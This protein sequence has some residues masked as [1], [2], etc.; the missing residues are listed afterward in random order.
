MTKSDFL[1]ILESFP[2]KIELRSC[3]EQEL[4]SKFEYLKFDGIVRDFNKFKKLTLP[5]NEEVWFKFVSF[6]V[7]ATEV[8]ATEEFPIPKAD[9][10]QASERI[11]DRIVSKFNEKFHHSL[12]IIQEIGGIELSE[13]IRFSQSGENLI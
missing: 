12:N 3:S 4:L 5:K 7:L 10:S 13:L 9:L 6:M 2:G 8:R 1:R 11:A